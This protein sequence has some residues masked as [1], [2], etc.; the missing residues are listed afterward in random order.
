MSRV[1]VRTIEV[2]KNSNRQ[3]VPELSEML[4]QHIVYQLDGEL[5]RLKSLRSVV[6]G[7]ARPS[8]SLRGFQA[9]AER[10]SP[11]ESPVSKDDPIQIALAERLTEPVVTAGTMRRRGRPRVVRA[12]EASEEALPV[13]S[14]RRT[15]LAQPTA[16]GKAASVGPVVI[17]AAALMREREARMAVKA[18]SAHRPQSEVELEV[19]PEVVARQ[20]AARWLASPDKL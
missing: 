2:F 20:L 18:A 10:V 7:L 5:T 19:R 17:S 4:L 6:A 14:H 1:R 9:R 12:D 16:L 8:A 3:V 15:K 13:R 11:T